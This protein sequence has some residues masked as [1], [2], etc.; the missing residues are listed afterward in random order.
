MP[1]D[2][3]RSAPAE[4]ADDEVP[5]RFVHHVGDRVG[6]D[7]VRAD[8]AVGD[9][10]ALDVLDD[11]PAGGP[12]GEL[13][14]ARR[15]LD[16]PGDRP[17]AAAAGR[18]ELPRRA[19]LPVLAR[20]PRCC[21]H[22]SS[23]VAADGSAAGCGHDGPRPE[24]RDVA[25]AGATALT[26]DRCRS[27]PDALATGSAPFGFVRRRMPTQRLG[28]AAAASRCRARSG[29]TLSEGSNQQ[30][31]PSALSTSDIER[32]EFGRP[33]VGPDDSLPRQPTHRC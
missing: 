9:T 8:G 23:S 18:A 25:G 30:C 27:T 13:S 11:R 15:E 21:K 5:A 22:Q 20:P 31:A 12:D 3:A 24:G 29:P 14:P 16:Q 1:S 17:D 28:A 19:D 26:V 10:P 4:V 7:A 32:S 33:L 6:R 2:R